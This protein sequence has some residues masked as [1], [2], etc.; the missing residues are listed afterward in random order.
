MKE[1]VTDLIKKENWEVITKSVEVAGG[2]EEKVQR[3]LVYG[4]EYPLKHPCLI[5]LNLYKN[6][7]NPEIK[8][9]HMKASHDY[10]WPDEVRTWNYWSEDRFRT[11]CEPWKYVGWSSGAHQGKSHDASKMGF[12]YWASDPKNRGVIIASTTL[13]SSGARVW[14]YLTQFINKRAIKVPL[15]YAG[16]K[17]PKVLYPRDKAEEEAEETISGIFAVAAKQ[18][19]DSEAINTWIG[20]HPPGGLLLILDECPD[21]NTAIAGAFINLDASTSPF[22]CLGL[23][24]ANSWFDLHGMLCYPKDGIDSIDPHI[25]TKWETTQKNGVCLYFNPYNSPAI[26]EKDPKKKKILSEF[27]ITEELIADKEKHY[28]KDSQDFSRMVMGFWRNKDADKTMVSKP[29]LDAHHVLSRPEW[30]GMNP[31]RMCAGLDPA[32]SSGGDSCM[33]QLGIIGETTDG[34]IVLD[35]KDKS[36]LYKLEISAKINKAVEIQIADQTIDILGRYGIPVNHLCVDANGQGR[37]LGGTIQLR[38]NALVGPTKIYSVRSGDTSVRSF[39]VKIMEA[40]ELWSTLRTFIE[41][42]QIC[43][44]NQIAMLQ[45]LNRMIITTDSK[46][47]PC[48][49]R[50]ENK[51]EFKSRMKGIMPALG[52]SPDE[53]DAGCLCLQ[54]AIIHCGFRVGQKRE[55]IAQNSYVDQKLTLFKAQMRAE[56]EQKK[57]ITVSSGFGS[58]VTDF[59]NIPFATQLK[60]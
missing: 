25:H 4:K 14:G 3:V 58:P 23:G 30:L 54:S 43:G 32:F 13:E 1:S 42:N 9:K 40:Y 2:L 20:R 29:F 33:L 49:P 34:G 5:H 12:L 47:K 11:H 41:N 55:P 21:L 59:K 46:G 38:A 22:Q 51:I 35:F 39:D 26:H 10:M 36:L 50:L 60:S 18:G 7:K 56:Q 31:L 52:H 45:L 37:A 24:N 8:F 15:R 19:G 16:G 57:D 28:Q 48:K 53:A 17:P 6:E 44:L 27:L